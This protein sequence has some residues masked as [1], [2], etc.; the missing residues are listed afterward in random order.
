MNS[1]N[2]SVSILAGIGLIGIF[3]LLGLDKSIDVVL[4]I[5]TMLI[6]AVA[7]LNKDNVVGAVG[8]IFKGKE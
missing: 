7:G 4:P 6:G 2:L 3:I 1:L 8:A 5:V